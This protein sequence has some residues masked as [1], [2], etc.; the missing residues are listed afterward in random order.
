[1]GLD[2]PYIVIREPTASPY[3]DQ[4]LTGAGKGGAAKARAKGK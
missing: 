1:M 3:A 4:V 2:H